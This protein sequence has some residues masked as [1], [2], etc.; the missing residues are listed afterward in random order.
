MV[1]DYL[2]VYSDT[3]VIAYIRQFDDAS[4]FLIVLNLSHRPCLFKP[5][6]T[7]LKGVVE[8]ATSPEWEGSTVSETI[9][10]GGDEGIL[11]RLE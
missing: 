6:D 11:V 4:R 9:N 1:G 10:L 3:Q 2:P 8:I 5:K 7:S